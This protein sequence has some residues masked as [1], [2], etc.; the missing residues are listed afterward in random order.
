MVIFSDD[1]SWC[2]EQTIFE[3]DRFLVAETRNPYVDMCLMTL[4]SDYIIANSTFSWWA[5]WLSH[6]KNKIVVYPN[7]GVGLNNLDKD[8]EELFPREWRMIDET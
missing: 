4:C 8:T 3:V 7:K 1:P 6:N 2:K 5:A